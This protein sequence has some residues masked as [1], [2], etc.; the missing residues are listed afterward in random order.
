M[1]MKTMSVQWFWVMLAGVLFFALGVIAFALP[2]HFT[3]TADDVLGGVF[4]LIGVLQGIY[5]YRA[6]ER[7]AIYLAAAGAILALTLGIWLLV[8]PAGGVNALTLLIAIFFAVQGAYEIFWAFQIRPEAPWQFVSANGC[9]SIALALITGFH[10]FGD[11]PGIVGVLIG[12][13]VTLSGL[14]LFL[15][16]LVARSHVGGEPNTTVDVPLP[17]EEDEKVPSHT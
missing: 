8:D 6:H 5:A 12:L 15:I 9:I 10:L 3:L 14:M 7:P 17:V 1:H 16:G 4:I 2:G 13:N 11:D